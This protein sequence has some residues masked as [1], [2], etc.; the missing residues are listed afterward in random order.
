MFTFHVDAG[1]G[2]LEVSA[3]DLA[4]LGMTAAHFSGYSYVSRDGGTFYLEED[5]DAFKF[6]SVWKAKHGRQ[7][8]FRENYQHNSFVRSLPRNA[9]RAIA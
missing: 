6:I 1:H 4:A 7:P 5:C 2:W 3:A 9:Q 8:E